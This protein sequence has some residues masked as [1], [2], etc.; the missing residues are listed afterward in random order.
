MSLDFTLREKAD[1]VI[2]LEEQKKRREA[3]LPCSQN[4]KGTCYAC[5]CKIMLIIKYSDEDCPLGYWPKVK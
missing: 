1:K 4:D 3:C 2:S 5:A